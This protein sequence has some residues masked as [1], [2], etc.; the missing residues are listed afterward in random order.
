MLLSRMKITRVF[1]LPNKQTFKIK[2]IKQLIERETKECRVIVDLFP[3]PFKRDAL[4]YAKEIKSVSVDCVLFDPPYSFHQL[5]ISYDNKGN[6]LT[7][8]YRSDLKNEICRILKPGGIAISFG[9][10]SNGI[11]NSRNHKYKVV[12]FNQYEKKRILLVAHGAGHNDTI[13]TVEQKVQDSLMNH[14]E[15]SSK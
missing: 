8:S 12:R 14:I 6:K 2:P 15:K 11:S 4:E 7:D 10:N 3:Y 9:W 13:V 5:N 1:A